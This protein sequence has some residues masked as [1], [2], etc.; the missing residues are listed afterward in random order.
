VVDAGALTYTNIDSVHDDESLALC[1]VQLHIL[2]DGFGFH[3]TSRQPITNW[4]EW[5]EK[6][7]KELT[8]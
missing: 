8:K 6:G 1:G 3:L 7:G 4:E 5:N 2:P